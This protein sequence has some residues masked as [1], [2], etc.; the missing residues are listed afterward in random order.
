MLSSS[1]ADEEPTLIGR[2]MKDF[3]SKIRGVEASNDSSNNCR[4]KLSFSQT[5]L[6][7]DEN[8]S[9]S[10]VPEKRSR[11]HDPLSSSIGRKRFATERAREVSSLEEENAQLK[12]QLETLK[13]EN[14]SDKAALSKLSSAHRNAELAQK[15][16][17]LEARTEAK[18]YRMKFEKELEHSKNLQKEM[19]QTSQKENQNLHEGELNKLRKVIQQY[20]NKISELRQESFKNKKSIE[21]LNEQN[22]NAK[23]KYESENSSFLH[24]IRCLEM[25]KKELEETKEINQKKGILSSKLETEIEALKGEALKKDVELRHLRDELAQNKE[26]L[27]QRKA[28]RQKLNEYPNLVRQVECLT[29]ENS[30]LVQTQE[31]VQ[32]LK[33]NISSLESEL[34]RKQKLL[35][36]NLPNQHEVHRL[37]KSISSWESAFKRVFMTG[38]NENMSDA[39]IGPELLNIKLADFQRTELLLRSNLGEAKTNKNIAESRIK[40]L[41]QDLNKSKTERKKIDEF[42]TEQAKRIKKLQR[43]LLLVARERDSYKSLLDSYEHEVTFAGGQL[44]KDKIAILESIISDHKDMVTKLEEQLDNTEGTVSIDSNSE[45]QKSE[46]EGKILALKKELD[47]ATNER[48]HLRYELDNRA[49]KGD[50]NPHNTRVIQFKNNPMAEASE[51]VGSKISKLQDENQSLKVRIQLLEEGHVKDLTLLS[52]QKMEKEISPKEVEDLQNKVKSSELKNEKLMEAFK[53]TSK[54]FRKLTQDLTGYRINSESGDNFYKVTSIYAESPEQEQLYF[55]KNQKGELLLL[56]NNYAET[57][58]HLIK[59]HL[60]M[61]DSIPAFLSGLTLDLI[62]KQS[63]ES[64]ANTSSSSTNFDAREPICID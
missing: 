46:Y 43:K 45:M 53:K 7:D 57:L 55:Q 13:L 5:V 26:Y 29:K 21:T 31:N 22:K 42:T 52:N 4:H 38:N 12:E 18:D 36:N 41:E 19:D 61:Q 11:F 37:Q 2:M 14:I 24:R 3:S 8:H 9:F 60:S 35:E 28:M 47:S 1:S 20:E 39:K 34:E 33:E 62:A 48:D 30:L 44:E 10:N 59:I 49:I 50:Y 58:N 15:R 51:N 54:E 32:L 25:D 23:Y 56:Q 6:F 64:E 27:I 40:A 63:I 16:Y 17:L